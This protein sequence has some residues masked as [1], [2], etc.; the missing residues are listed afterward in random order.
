MLRYISPPRSITVRWA[1]SFLGICLL[2]FAV[3]AL[4]AQP[5][6]GQVS[7]RLDI[8]FPLA[9]I[10]KTDGKAGVRESTLTI[11]PIPTN[12][13]EGPRITFNSEVPGESHQ[14]SILPHLQVASLMSAFVIESPWSSV[15][16]S[17]QSSESADYPGAT[18]T[19]GVAMIAAAHRRAWPEKTAILA[20]VRPDTTLSPI[21]R[22]KTFAEQLASSGIK[23]IVTAPGIHPRS[24]YRSFDEFSK[25]CQSKNIKVI[26]ARHLRDAT[27]LAFGLDATNLKV[28]AFPDSITTNMAQVIDRESKL[29]TDKTASL[30]TSAKPRGNRKGKGGLSPASLQESAQAHKQTAFAADQA[31]DRLRANELLRLALIQMRIAQ[32][33]AG[34]TPETDPDKLLGGAQSTR[35]QLNNLLFE[36][37]DRDPQLNNVLRWTILEQYISDLYAGVETAGNIVAKTQ[38]YPPGSKTA[39]S[40]RDDL[41]IIQTAVKAVIAEEPT[42][43]VLM[44][45]I[46]Q[47]DTTL[48]YALNGRQIF[49]QVS[50]AFEGYAELLARELLEITPRA[51][52][53][54]IHDWLFVF[55]LHRWSEKAAKT[56]YAKYYSDRRLRL[57]EENLQASQFTLGGGYMPPIPKPKALPLDNISYEFQIFHDLGNI[58]RISL[59]RELYGIGEATWEP[60][61]FS[62]TLRDTKFLDE[63][64][65]DGEAMARF[66]LNKIVGAPVNILPLVYL[67]EKCRVMSREPDQEIRLRALTGLWR[68]SLMAMTIKMMTFENLKEETPPAP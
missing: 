53:H 12:P 51:R 50:P 9:F 15:D 67:Y 25:W 58:S 56:Y 28:D 24:G 62:Y 3:G 41:D 35:N 11:T 23:T 5:P 21:P 66:A 20:E 30:D 65:S 22:L 34:S 39:A 60:S 42:P 43:L 37:P 54:L 2:S 61:K 17:I 16:F 26:T 19:L 45:G 47:M 29:R 52:D 57:A 7:E 36:I 49:A 10:E 31:G 18:A 14:L 55:T 64:L 6:P 13:A 44:T 63:A 59:L 48:P 32:A 33:V 4:P 68:V 40:A 1:D 8:R 38:G 46:P 27:R